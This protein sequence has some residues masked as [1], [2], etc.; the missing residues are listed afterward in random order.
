MVGIW[1]SEIFCAPTERWE[2]VVSVDDDDA[3]WLLR[4]NFLLTDRYLDSRE[5]YA[6]ELREWATGSRPLQGLRSKI[7]HC[8]EEIELQTNVGQRVTWEKWHE[9]LDINK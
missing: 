8:L 1:R 4:I 7:G 9:K 2:F 6:A 3:R 5:Y